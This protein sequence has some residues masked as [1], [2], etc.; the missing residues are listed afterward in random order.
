MESLLA[1]NEEPSGYPPVL[2]SE[3]FY[4][5]IVKHIEGG[6]TWDEIEYV[7]DYWMLAWEIGQQRNGCNLDKDFGHLLKGK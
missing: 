3:Y 7:I 5:D 6:G 4:P 2:Y 1:T